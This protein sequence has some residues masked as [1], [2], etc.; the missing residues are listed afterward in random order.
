M[1][2]LVLALLMGV[3]LPPSA[4]LGQTPEV[5]CCED[6]SRECPSSCEITP[7]HPAFFFSR[8]NPASFAPKTAD[9]PCFK[10]PA[11]A[12]VF[13]IGLLPQGDVWHPQ[14]RPWQRIPTE[15]LI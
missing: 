9:I 11:Q 2:L 13:T 1:R 15:L 5:L 12:P 4:T 3:I 14:S 7:E 8:A 6:I 10:A